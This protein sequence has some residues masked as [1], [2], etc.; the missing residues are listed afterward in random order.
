MEDLKQSIEVSKQRELT[1][2]E[3]NNQLKHTQLDLETQLRQ[4]QNEN[5]S[6]KHEV[7]QIINYHGLVLKI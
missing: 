7:I 1:T 3:Q 5:A 6:T 4:L 2:Q